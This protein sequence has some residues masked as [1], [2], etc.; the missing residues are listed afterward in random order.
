MFYF[1]VP[2]TDKYIIVSAVMDISTSLDSS[3][4]TI[5][6][7]CT[8]CGGCVRQCAFLRRYGNPLQ[9][10]TQYREETLSPEVIYSCSLCR[11]CDVHC[12][13]ALQIQDML[14]LMRCSL[15]E[16]GRGP[17][18]QHRRLLAYEKWGLSR[19]LRFTALPEG[20]DTVFYPGCA[21]VGTRPT[22]TLKLFELLRKQIPALGVVLNCCAKPSHDLGRFEFFEK[23]FNSQIAN[24]KARGI[25]TVI[26]ACPSCYQVF[27]R[28][29]TE[30]EVKT[31]YQVLETA[32]GLQKVD[33]EAE[34]CVHDP[35]STRFQT[36][37]H[38]SVRSIVEQQGITVG[39]LKHQGKRTLCCG[40][41]GSA[42]FVAPEITDRWAEQRAEQAAGRQ[43][44]TY[45]A[46]CV[47][48]LSGQMDIVHLVDLM[49]APEEA[50][51][52]NAP[53]SKSPFTYLNRLM[54]KFKLK[55]NG[56]NRF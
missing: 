28:Y 1:C 56:G 29:A 50:L 52:G 21:L 18:K 42:G 47:Q 7:D 26:T 5:I 54:L 22:Q 10:A 17:L 30:I 20:A 19:L 35:C 12:P 55:R 11:L 45:C 38:Q 44:I 49:L 40:E 9:L 16:E 34:M 36:A 15:V 27:D 23:V 3:L 31:I 24:L 37:V 48:F 39:R 2:I 51:S 14:W 32:A 4:N 46:G 13:E 53:A 41:G 6:A 8:E 43:V 33:A 25:T